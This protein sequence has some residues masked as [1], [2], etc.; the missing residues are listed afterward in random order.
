MGLLAFLSRD[1]IRARLCLGLGDAAGAALYVLDP[2][3][4]HRNPTAG[5]ADAALARR[6]LS[7]LSGAHQCIFSAASTQRSC[8]M[9]F[10]SAII[11]AAERVPLPDVVVRAAIHELCSRNAAR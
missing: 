10:V 1:R 7:R 2:G 11:G 9:N 6:P 5:S 8:L 3:P 4:R